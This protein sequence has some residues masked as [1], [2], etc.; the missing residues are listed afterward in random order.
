VPA[1]DWHERAQGGTSACHTGA[2]LSFVSFIL[3]DGSLIDVPLWNL[4]R[5]LAGTTPYS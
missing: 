5:A 1:P 3:F 2:A 4:S